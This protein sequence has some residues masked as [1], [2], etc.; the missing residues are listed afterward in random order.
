MNV[1]DT[2]GYA[3]WLV[4][5]GT[6][7]SSPALAGIVNNA[8]N[9]LGQSGAGHYHTGENNLLYSQLLSYTAYPANFYDVSTGSNGVGHNAG[10]GYDECTGVGS[11][12]GKK[13][14]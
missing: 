11:P 13:G 5:G 12:R 3:G 1:Y 14:K 9:R 2:Y 10:I 8:N 6:S 4:V 7:V